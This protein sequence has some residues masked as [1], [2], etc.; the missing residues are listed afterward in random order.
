MASQRQQPVKMQR[1]KE[2]EK[3]GQLIL[4]KGLC[5]ELSS[6]VVLSLIFFKENRLSSKSKINRIDLFM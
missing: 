6:F 1:R 4:H 5:E 3:V 2:K